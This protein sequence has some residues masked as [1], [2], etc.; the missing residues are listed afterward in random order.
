MIDNKPPEYCDEDCII[1][2]RNTAKAIQEAI[3]TERLR[4][5][6]EIAEL[7]DIL[8]NVLWQAC[9]NVKDNVIDTDCLSAMEN[10]CQY[11]K[12]KGILDTK[13]GR[14]YEIIE[15]LKKRLEAV[16]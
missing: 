13:N 7:N 2:D 3:K 10:A 16:K 9:G 6:R 5:K 15:D 11:L 8:L 14:T 12:Q 1:K 4:N